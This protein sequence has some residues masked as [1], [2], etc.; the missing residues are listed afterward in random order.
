MYL[1]GIYGNK[2][3]KYTALMTTGCETSHLTPYMINIQSIINI[4]QFKNHNHAHNKIKL[5]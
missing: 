5:K 4:T 1:N 3:N 2:I